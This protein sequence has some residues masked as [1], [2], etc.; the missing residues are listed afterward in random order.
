MDTASWMRPVAMNVRR[1]QRESPHY[2][3]Q[4]AGLVRTVGPCT[5][6][7]VALMPQ[8]IELARDALSNNRC[9]SAARFE[10]PAEQALALVTEP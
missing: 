3:A 9:K 7:R 6:R 10:R 4:D 2:K 5:Q 1:G 8:A